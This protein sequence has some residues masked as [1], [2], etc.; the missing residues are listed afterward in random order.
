[1][2]AGV[3]LIKICPPRHKMRGSV[4]QFCAQSCRMRCNLSLV[5]S[6]GIGI[7]NVLTCRL[8]IEMTTKGMH[9]KKVRPSILNLAPVNFSA[10]LEADDLAEPRNYHSRGCRIAD[11]DKGCSAQSGGNT[12]PLPQSHSALSSASR[13]LH[14]SILFTL[15]RLGRR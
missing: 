6:L 8:I 2:P 10:W 7:P 14:S 4:G 15:S 12:S 11:T 1:M 3:G 5:P 13:A 9:A